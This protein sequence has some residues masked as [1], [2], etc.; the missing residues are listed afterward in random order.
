ME[1]AD[2]GEVDERIEVVLSGNQCFYFCDF[3][4]AEEFYDNYKGDVL[5]VQVYFDAVDVQDVLDMFNCQTVSSQTI[6][7]GVLYT[8]FTSQYNAGLVENGRKTNIQ[9]YFK[10]G[11]VIVG[12]P[13]IFTGF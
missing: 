12:F 9:I 7:G 4:V 8:A 11:E 5:G 10:N 1:N 13:Q 2:I 6:S 3:P